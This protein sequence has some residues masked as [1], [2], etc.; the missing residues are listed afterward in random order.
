MGDFK[1]DTF[2][3][4]TS[5]HTFYSP[6]IYQRFAYTKNTEHCSIHCY[7]DANDMC[8]FHFLYNGYCNLGNFNTESPVGSSSVTTDMY[9]FKGK[10]EMKKRKIPYIRLSLSQ[11]H[12]ATIMMKQN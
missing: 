9:I 12:P 8:D 6:Y 3:T 4:R 5:S 1:S 10:D 7:F 2:V 11:V